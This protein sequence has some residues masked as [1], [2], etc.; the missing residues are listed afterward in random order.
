[1]ISIITTNA[2]NLRCEYCFEHKKANKNIS[3]ETV[4]KFIDYVVDNTKKWNYGRPFSVSFLGGEPLL[5]LGIIEDTMKYIQVKQ[6]IE[7]LC[8]EILCGGATTN[9]VAATRPEF[10]E[11]YKKYPNFELY[12]SLDGGPASHDS[13]R[14]HPDG[15]GSSAE[16]L[17]DWDWVQEHVRSINFV[18][19]RKNVHLF[20]KSMIF[21]NSYYKK[22]VLLLLE[23]EGLAFD[24]EWL[25]VYLDQIEILKQWHKKTMVQNTLALSSTK[26]GACT[27][28]DDLELAIHPSGDIT[29]CW[30]LGDLEDFSLG[31]IN[32]PETLKVDNY[33]PCNVAEEYRTKLKDLH[34]HRCLS[35]TIF[36]L[37][38][39]EKEG[40][41]ITPKVF[42]AILD[43][44]GDLAKFLNEL[45]LNIIG[46]EYRRALN[47]ESSTLTANNATNLRIK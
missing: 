41:E 35:R 15:T 12:G 17:K 32:E 24:E 8:F 21:L 28:C 36:G 26:F 31:N 1:M 14:K 39:L 5:N 3:F 30:T 16:I 4:K 19:T 10:K 33:R 37:K 44:L 18:L 20:A 22:K 2:C 43:G 42:N 13:S 29:P 25:K 6:L 45:G 46:N 9:I 38:Q 7:N 40:K 23:N 47:E 27:M 11:F 34:G